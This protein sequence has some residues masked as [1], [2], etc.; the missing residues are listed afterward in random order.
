MR[1][2]IVLFFLFLLCTPAFALNV[3]KTVVEQ[4]TAIIASFSRTDAEDV[5]YGTGLCVAGG[6]ILTA[7]HVV[8]DI[9]RALGVIVNNRPYEAKLSFVDERMDIAAIHT[10]LAFEPLNLKFREAKFLDR[11]YVFWCSDL[12]GKIRA[13]SCE[14]SREHQ[15]V[16]VFADLNFADLVG[17]NG[18]LSHGCS[19]GLA[20]SSDGN[21]VISM[22]N[23][24]NTTSISP[25]FFGI[26]GAIIN[27][28]LKLHGILS[29]SR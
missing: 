4:R 22:V 10:N 25:E 9:N 8:G 28:F 18:A 20:F 11:G 13:S 6:Y 21:E 1:K 12:N 27:M 15:L 26:R 29:A 2:S 3:T 19:G 14:V 16:D 17:F 24:V 7:N 5:A 23:V